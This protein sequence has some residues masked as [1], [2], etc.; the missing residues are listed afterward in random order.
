VDNNIDILM[1][2]DIIGG[3][4]SARVNQNL[5]V[6]K[7]WSYGAFTFLQDARGQRPWVVYAPVQS[8]RTADAVSELLAEFNRFLES[9]PAT[10]DELTRVYRSSAFSLPG[11]Y[12]T[13][14]AVLTAMQANDRFGRPDDYV[15]SL[16]EKYQSV[17]LENI[18]GAAE[19]VIHPDSITW[20]IVGDRSRIE[21][22]LTELGIAQPEFMDPAG[23][24][25]E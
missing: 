12:E 13:A 6:D 1:M 17:S 9:E 7:R 2:N 23:K 19:N 25:I 16:K 8:D 3:K 21:Q 14:A 4:S 20:V 18:Q 10:A 22:G 11:R 24:L 15:A 5:R